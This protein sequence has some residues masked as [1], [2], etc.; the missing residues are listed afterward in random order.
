MPTQPTHPASTLRPHLP[1]PRSLAV[2]PA[3]AAGLLLSLAALFPAAAQQPVAPATNPA[4]SA[5]PPPPASPVIDPHALYEARC[6]GCHA[7]HGGDFAKQS[8][9]AVDGVVIGARSGRPLGQILPSHRGTT[10]TPDEVKALVDHF[11][12]IL[13]TGWLYQDK[14]LGCHDRAVVLARSHLIV[15]DD[16]LVGRY[17]GRDI[18]AFM[19]GHGRLDPRQRDIILAM[20]RRQLESTAP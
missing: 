7:P 4:P 11:G 16:A 20:L 6:S 12:A 8:L 3:I 18:A 15:R 10:Q 17:S 1:S 9:K 13:P 19:S 5:S 14:C 2:W